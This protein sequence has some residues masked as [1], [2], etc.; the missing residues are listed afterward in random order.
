MSSHCMSFQTSTT[1]RL[2]WFVVAVPLHLD[3]VE[4]SH[5][6]Q[7]SDRRRNTP[8]SARIVRDR[9]VPFCGY[10]AGYFVLDLAEL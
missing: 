1:V 5:S 3:L 7:V 2:K 9:C 6:K 4:L 10:R 8:K